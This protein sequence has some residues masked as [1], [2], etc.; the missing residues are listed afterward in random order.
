MYA[1]LY[2]R[3]FTSSVDQ[4]LEQDLNALKEE[5]TPEIHPLDD[6]MAILEEDSGTPIV[7]E[8]NINSRGVQHPFYNM[9]NI[10]TRSLGGVDWCC[11]IN[12]SE[13]FWN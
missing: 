7:S 2:K 5:Y 9:V 4:K 6:L 3:R 11:G 10:V 13:P 1:A 12:L 8:N